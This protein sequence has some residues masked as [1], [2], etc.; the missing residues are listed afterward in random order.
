MAHLLRALK[1][2]VDQSEPLKD[3]V[4]GYEKELIPR[5][6]EEVKCCVENGEM[7]HDWNKVKES[8]VFRRGFA[9]MEGHNKSSEEVA[10]ST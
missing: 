1:T 3:L 8:P 7:L 10:V 6:A 2:V 4:G 5:G 9:P